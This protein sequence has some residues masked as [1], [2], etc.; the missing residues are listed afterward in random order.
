MEKPFCKICHED[1]STRKNPLLHPCRCRGSIGCTHKE[2]LQKWISVSKR[3]HCSEC[4]TAYNLV[5]E[6]HPIYT[7][8][9]S[10]KIFL[11]FYLPLHFLFYLIQPQTYDYKHFSIVNRLVYSIV[12]TYYHL[13]IYASYLFVL[14][15]FILFIIAVIV[16]VVT[17]SFEIHL[18]GDDLTPLVNYLSSDYPLQTAIS[19]EYR[20][21]VYGSFIILTGSILYFLYQRNKK[22]SR[23]TIRNF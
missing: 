2:C 18:K 16:D 14:A 12:T 3:I 23:L 11:I 9:E 8:L 13:T 7:I 20:W 5:Y 22:S 4:K 21:V 6:S 10:L 15:F 17:L 19:T 1:K